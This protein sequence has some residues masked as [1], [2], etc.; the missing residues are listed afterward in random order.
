MPDALFAAYV[1]SQIS[2][3]PAKMFSQLMRYG[4]DRITSPHETADLR[5][6]SNSSRPHLLTRPY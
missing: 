6:L 3:H 5:S 1:V 2:L 4:V